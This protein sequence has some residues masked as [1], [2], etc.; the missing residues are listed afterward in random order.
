[1]NSEEI[2]ARA[3]ETHR[4]MVKDIEDSA[5]RLDNDVYGNPAWYVPIFMFSDEQG[6]WF[7]PFNVRA[8]RGKKYGAGWRIETYNLRRSIERSIE[9]KFDIQFKD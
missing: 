9:E 3:T 8:Y 2:K 4:Q 5:I 7:R 1:M 6:N